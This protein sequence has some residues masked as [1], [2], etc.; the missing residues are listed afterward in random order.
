MNSLGLRRP[1]PFDRIDRPSIQL[2]P[3]LR[4]ETSDPESLSL[5][6]RE[7]FRLR[8]KKGRPHSL[9]PKAPRR[10]QFW[11]FCRRG[12]APSSRPRPKM[13]ISDPEQRKFRAW[14]WSPVGIRRQET[15]RLWLISLSTD[16]TRACLHCLVNP[17]KV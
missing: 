9:T 14:R 3:Q 17:R 5:E 6:P 2:H 10:I 16:Y 4:N 13:E 7:L 11:A 12:V 1:S 8:P 15:S